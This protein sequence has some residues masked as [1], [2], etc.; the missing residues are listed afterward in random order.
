MKTWIARVGAIALFLLT[1]AAGCRHDAAGDLTPAGNTGTAGDLTKGRWTVSYFNE[2]GTDMTGHLAGYT[3]DFQSGGLLSVS[4]GAQTVKGTWRIEPDDSHS[5]FIITLEG[6]D[7]MLAELQDDW[8]ILANTETAL[9]LRH[10]HSGNSSH[11][12]ELHFDRQP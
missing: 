10:S 1:T 7:P 5:E 12:M 9:N 2:N 3:F 11:T 4:T 6:A 8:D